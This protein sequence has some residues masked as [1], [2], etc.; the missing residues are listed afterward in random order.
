MKSSGEVLGN[1]NVDNA[2]VYKERITADSH[3]YIGA[4][5]HYDVGSQQLWGCHPIGLGFANRANSSSCDIMAPADVSGHAILEAQLGNSLNKQLSPKS[6]DRII[7][8]EQC[9]N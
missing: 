1:G 6:Y 3:G 7:E 9:V 2:S 5:Q 8:D 4:V